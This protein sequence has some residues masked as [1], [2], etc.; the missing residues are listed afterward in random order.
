MYYITDK[1]TSRLL[2]KSTVLNIQNSIYLDTFYRKLTTQTTQHIAVQQFSSNPLFSS[3]H[4]PT[5]V[6][7]IQS[8]MIIIKLHSIPITIGT[9]YS[10]LRHNIMN[11]IFTEMFNLIKNIFIKGGNFNAKHHAWGCRAN[12]PRDI[13]LHNFT[14]INN[15]NILSPPKPT[16]WPSSLRKK[17]DILDI[18]VTKNTQRFILFC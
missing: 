18:F 8:Y 10:P 6:V 2:A 13:I 7:I 9:F 3:S 15:F 5:T 14:N 4:I 1:Q 12:N 17:P 11:F 16:Y